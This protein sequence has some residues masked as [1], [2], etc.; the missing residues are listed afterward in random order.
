MNDKHTIEILKTMLTKYPLAKE[1]DEAV[2]DAIGIL[3]W[4]KLSEGRMKN[5]KRA[6]EKR[7]TGDD[8]V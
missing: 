5:L 1:E 3:A 2:R 8:A 6:R 4:T 7:R